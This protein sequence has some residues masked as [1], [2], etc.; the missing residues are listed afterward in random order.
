MQGHLVRELRGQLSSR[1]VWGDGCT[2][3]WPQSQ[4]GGWGERHRSRATGPR[5]GTPAAAWG[6]GAFLAQTLFLLEAGILLALGACALCQLELSG[7]LK[8]TPPR[9]CLHVVLHLICILFT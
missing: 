1:N 8:K 7:W 2:C 6:W 5:K 4:D 9:T 3:D